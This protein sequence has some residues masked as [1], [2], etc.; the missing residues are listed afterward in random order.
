MGTDRIPQPNIRQRLES[1]A[2]EG[3]EGL[4]E[5]E[6]LGIHNKNKAHRIN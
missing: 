2:K 4:E 6:G 5:P 1:P 3:E